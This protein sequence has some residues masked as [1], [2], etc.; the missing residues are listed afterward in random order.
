VY[1]LA[2]GL[3]PAEVSAEENGFRWVSENVGEKTFFCRPEVD[4][5]DDVD[6][7]DDVDAN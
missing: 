7:S 5:R 1:G 6:A 2:L 4:A 3:C